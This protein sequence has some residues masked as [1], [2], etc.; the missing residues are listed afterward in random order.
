MSTATENAN[1]NSIGADV[2]A[3]EALNGSDS[4]T[5]NSDAKKEVS[6]KQLYEQS[7]QYNHWRYTQS[8]LDELRS[9]ANQEVIAII[10][11]NIREER[12]QRI[13]QGLTVDDLPQDLN[14][15]TV[16]EE[17]ALLGFYQRRIVQI[18]R[19]W[20]L[21]SYVTATAIVYMKRFFLENTIMDYHPKD[22]MLTCMFLARKTENFLMTIDDFSSVFKSGA[23]PILNLEFLVCKNLRFHFAVHH[24]YR[25]CLGFFYDMQAVTDNMEKL[26]KVYEVALKLIDTSLYTDLCFL[27]QPSQI[28]LAAMRIAAKDESYDFERYANYKFKSNESATQ[29]YNETLLP[30]LQEIER[31]LSEDPRCIEVDKVVATGIDERLKLCKDPAR[32]PDSLM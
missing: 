20:K 16:E 25:P 31:V 21:P 28:A 27:Y 10:R 4:T 8:A 5:D 14:F 22:V 29:K 26:Q 2:I 3:T 24:P 30:I 11:E 23:D 12:E 15:L 13:A 19:Y 7:T 1:G 6:L 32:N 18:F 17:L 9:K